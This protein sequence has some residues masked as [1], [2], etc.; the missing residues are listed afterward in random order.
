MGKDTWSYGNILVITFGEIIILTRKP[1]REFVI[2]PC[3][4]QSREQFPEGG[5]VKPKMA[6]DIVSF[7]C[8]PSITGHYYS[9]ELAIH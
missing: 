6:N 8:A 2:R 9:T 3:T 7:N 5:A 4:V 1:L